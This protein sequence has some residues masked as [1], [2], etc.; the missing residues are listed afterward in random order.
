MSLSFSQAQAIAA[1]Q[2][3]LPGS[4]T[5]LRDS[6]G[7]VLADDV[8]ARCAVS[9][10]E[11]A[12]MDGYAVNAS[13]GHSRGPW[14]LRG[15]AP[16]DGNLE[17]DP[18]DAVSIVTGGAVPPSATSVVRIEHTHTIGTQLEIRN[19]NV[20]TRDLTPGAHI[21]EAGLEESRGATILRA[22]ALM[23][24]A[25]IA[26][27]AVAAIDTL[28]CVP[29]PKVGYVFTG[30]E[31]LTEG[32]PGPGYVRDAFSPYFSA[33]TGNL[34]HGSTKIPARADF[35]ARIGDELAAMQRYLD[36][37]ATEVDVLITTGGTGFSSADYLRRALD[38]ADATYLI[39]EIDMR[40][41][42]PTVLA[43]LPTGTFVLGLPGNPLAAIAGFVAVGMPLLA[44][45]SGIGE[46]PQFFLP[47]GISATNQ[48]PSKHRPNKPAPQTPRLIPAAY[49]N[50]V[51]EASSFQGSA[52]LR[53]LVGAEFLAVTYPGT[54]AP[55]DQTRILPLPWATFNPPT[56]QGR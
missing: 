42:H 33:L 21:R 38:A 43:Q 13:G 39:P 46:L 28:V 25:E 32:I 56:T 18:G 40:P 20:D 9:H 15:A 6:F 48:K 1:A 17:L 52:M 16:R 35:E 53:G 10:Y 12:A 51:I 8:Q 45:L 23:G 31:V 22:G 41:G 5:S 14:T 29:A 34:Q 11:S 19:E 44:A 49:R 24:P 2:S 37:A 26:A 7:L 30:D 3:S 54:T 4:Q 27:A 50:G 47:A 55:G 36:R